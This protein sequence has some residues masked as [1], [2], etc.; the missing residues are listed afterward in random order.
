[1]KL[2]GS[3]SN[4]L[5]GFTVDETADGARDGAGHDSTT[6]ATT[7]HVAG[8]IWGHGQPAQPGRASGHGGR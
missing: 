2:D 7:A 1:M 3:G 8:T 6:N 5:C 4:T